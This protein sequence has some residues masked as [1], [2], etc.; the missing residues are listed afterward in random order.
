M[1][2]SLSFKLSQKDFKGFDKSILT[3]E[4]SLR[5]SFVYLALSSYEVLKYLFVKSTQEDKFLNQ[6]IS[7]GPDIV[8]QA[9]EFN[10]E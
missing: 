9:K 4:I 1:I 7:I 8:Y 5:Y 2:D 10:A 3:T 6:L